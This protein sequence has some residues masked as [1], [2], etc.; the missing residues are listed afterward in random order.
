[1]DVGQDFEVLGVQ[2]G[3]I[4]CGHLHDRTWLSGCRLRKQ[5]VR[6]STRLIAWAASNP[7]CG[8]FPYTGRQ[9]PFGSNRTG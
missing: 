8:A 7:I 9:Q 5:A 1:L 3:W 2:G 6:T 4:S